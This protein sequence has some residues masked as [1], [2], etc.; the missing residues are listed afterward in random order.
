M[1]QRE[2]QWGK[3]PLLL[4]QN[5][6]LDG[7]GLRF[8]PCEGGQDAAPAEHG[9]KKEEERRGAPL[10]SGQQAGENQT[11]RSPSVSSGSFAE[12]AEHQAVEAARQPVEVALCLLIERIELFL[13]HREKVR[14]LRWGE[15]FPERMEGEADVEQDGGFLRQGW[16]GYRDP[17]S[18]QIDADRF[19]VPGQGA[20][21][22]ESDR[23]LIAGHREVPRIAERSV[24]AGGII[25]G[26]AEK[27]IIVL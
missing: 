19:P 1:Q 22:G 24:L 12:S 21:G 20:V 4:V 23:D 8:L 27:L 14:S 3:R 11:H 5:P 6:N 10:K 7:S 9:G 17:C 16:S 18:R 25:P 2:K 13:A 15:R 26:Q